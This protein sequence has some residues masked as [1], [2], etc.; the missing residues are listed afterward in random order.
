[1]TKGVTGSVSIWMWIVGGVIAGLILFT[2]AYSQLTQTTQS[3]VKQR[4]L[5]QYEEL[6]NQINGLCWSF[7]E[8]VREYSLILDESVRGIYLTSDKYIEINNSQFIEY[9]SDENISSG[10]YLCI[11]VE[12]KRTNCKKLDCTAKMP[13]L[14]AIPTKF[15]LEALL[16]KIMGNYEKFE[17][18]LE[19]VKEGDLV[20]ITKKYGPQ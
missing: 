2:I 5:E 20:N 14:G 13:Y 10:Y 18:T 4:S 6:F 8:N 1:M 16:N 3:M 7:S 17:Y 12:G 15:S 11:K 9:I 19:L